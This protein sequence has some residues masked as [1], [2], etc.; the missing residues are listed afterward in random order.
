[1][2][3]CLFECVRLCTCCW[4]KFGI[5]QRR[6]G[7]KTCC[8][9]FTKD[10]HFIFPSSTQT[11]GDYFLTSRKSLRSFSIL[12]P[13]VFFHS[14]M[15]FLSCTFVLVE[16]GP[17]LGRARNSRRPCERTAVNISWP[18]RIQTQSTPCIC[19]TVSFLSQNTTRISF[20]V[21][22]SAGRENGLLWPCRMWP[23]FGR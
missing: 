23:W 10:V 14:L 22:F 18:S 5:L 19:S 6:G 1:M 12:P 4:A 9:M 3:A 13:V 17:A 16:S 8:G 2:C 11:N 7:K 20:K 15:Y 21:F